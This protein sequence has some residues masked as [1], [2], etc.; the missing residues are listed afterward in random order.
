MLPLPGIDGV[1]GEHDRRTGRRQVF[2]D[3]RA[4]ALG[5]ACD[6]SALPFQF[7]LSVSLARGPFTINTVP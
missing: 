7:T 2:G 4:D 1:L 6:D 5:R 3:L